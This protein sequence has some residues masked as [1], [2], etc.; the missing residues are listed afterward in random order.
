M[1]P[2]A[3]AAL[4]AKIVG[5]LHDNAMWV[6]SEDIHGWR[7]L[8]DHLKACGLDYPKCSFRDDDW[9]DGCS[10]FSEG[11]EVKGIELKVTCNCGQVTDR[12]QRYSGSHVELINGITGLDETS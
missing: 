9:W 12:P 6:T 1:T 11:H 2:E 7:E 3:K 10:T 8:H 5:W 4:H